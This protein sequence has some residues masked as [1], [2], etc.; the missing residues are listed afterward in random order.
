M[1]ELVTPAGVRCSGSV[2]SELADSSAESI[3][4]HSQFCGGDG[5]GRARCC[6]AKEESTLAGVARKRCGALELS[7]CLVEAAELREKITAHAGQQVITGKRRLG[8]ELIDDF[9]SRRRTECHRDR[10]GPIQLD[11]GGGRDE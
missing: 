3:E 7:A 4:T 9:E 5:T 1:D 11:D 2:A 6:A 8:P 10:Y